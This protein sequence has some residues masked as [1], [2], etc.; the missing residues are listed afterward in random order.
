MGQIKDVWQN[1]SLRKSIAAYLTAFTGLAVLLCAVTISLC[2]Q[3]ETKINSRYP[4]FGEEVY[5]LTNQ[6]GQQLGEGVRIGTEQMP[7]TRED[8]IKVTALR[9]IQIFCMPVYSA[10]CIVGAALLFYRNRLKKPIGLLTEAARKIAEND[11]DFCVSY[12]RRDELGT[13]CRAFET[14]RFALQCNI[15][16]MGRQMEERKRLNSAFAHD[17]RTPLTVLK[18]YGEILQASPDEQTQKTAVTM[19][20][21]IDRLTHYADSMSRLRRLEDASPQYQNVYAVDFADS[22]RECAQMLC[23]RGGKDMHMEERIS[24]RQIYIDGEFV[25]Q[26]CVN[27]IS[28]AVRYAKSLVTFALEEKETGILISVTDD[29]KGFEEDSLQY[30][31]EPYYTEEENHFEHFGLGL[32]ICKVLCGHHGGDLTIENTGKGARAAAFFKFGAK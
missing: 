27:L 26:V 1:L 25:S 13:L 18:G 14:M 19:G 21:H 16:E 8:E 15:S 24:S 2:D 7:M 9:K 10:L 28:N 3:G 22:L 20:K 29:G 5:Y 12:E 17:L 31:L 32:Y 4:L 6:Q 30:A 23:R 11:L